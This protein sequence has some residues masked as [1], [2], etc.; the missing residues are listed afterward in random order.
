M[1]TTASTLPDLTEPGYVPS[2]ALGRLVDLRDVT[3]VFPGDSTPARRTDRDHRLP[4]PL[5]QTDPGNL[6]SLSRHWHRAKHTGWT[7]RTTD[8]G[9]IRW[10]SPGGGVYRRRPHRT[11][12]PPVPPDAALPPLPGAP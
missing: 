10:S 7:S 8:D 4:W 3:S 11:A 6:Q 2:A 9:T 12:P 5:G 1:A